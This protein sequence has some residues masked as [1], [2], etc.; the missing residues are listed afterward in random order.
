MRVLRWADSGDYSIGEQIDNYGNIVGST[1]ADR[2]DVLFDID[3]VSGKIFL[4]EDKAGRARLRERHCHLH[5]VDN[6]D[7]Y[8]YWCT[9]RHHSRNRGGRE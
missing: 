9:V 4:K 7:V 2:D 6:K 8:H 5:F 1:A 3:K